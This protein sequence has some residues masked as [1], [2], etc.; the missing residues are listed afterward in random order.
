MA[1]SAGDRIP[2][3]QLKMV[4]EHGTEQAGTAE[5]LGKGRIVLFGVP[6]AFTPVCSDRHL[7]GFVA[8]STEI[9]SRGV[10]GI[11]CVAVND[12]YVMGAWARWQGVAGRVKMLADGNGEFARATGLEIDLSGAGLGIRNKRYAAIL[13][14]GVVTYIAVEDGG[15]LEVS[16]AERL[17]AA[18]S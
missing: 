14:N 5:V 10:D 2:D 6:G 3:V 8:R 17:L 16:S 18:L 11:Y 13:E 15:G 4:G 9:L 1:I 12:H 7:P